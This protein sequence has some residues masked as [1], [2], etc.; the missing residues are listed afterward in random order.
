MKWFSFPGRDASPESGFRAALSFILIFILLAAGIITISYIFFQSYQRSFRVEAERQ[1]EAVAELKINELLRWRIEREGD[2]N[3]FYNNSAFVG[4]VRRLYDQPEDVETQAQLQNWM[5]KIS[6]YGQYDRAWLMDTQSVTRLSVPGGQQPSAAPTMRMVS[7]VLQS[8]RP[9]FQDFYRNEKDQRVYLAVMVPIFDESNASRPLGVLVLRIDPTAYLY[10]FIQRWPVPGAK[11][12]ETLLVRREENEVVY[13]NELRFQADTALNLRFPITRTNLPAVKVALGQEGVVEGTDYRGIP[14]LAA[15]KAVPDSPWFMVTRQDKAEVFSPIR[16]RLYQMV[17]AIGLMLFSAA[18]CVGLVWRQQRVGFY[19]EKILTMKALIKS[20]AVFRSYF[21]LPLH[22]LAV[23]SVEKGW[24]KV[25][26]HLCSILGYTREEIVRM[27]WAE[28]THPRDLDADVEQF[29]RLLAGQIEKYEM[30]KRFVR[31]DGAVV[32]TAIAAGCVREADG[33]ADHFICSIDDITA[34]K[35][36]EEKLA[37]TIAELRASNRDLEQFAYIASHD[38][39]EPLRMVA[40][41][42]QLLERRYKDKL[43]QDANDFIGFAVDGALRMRQ[44]IDSLLEYSQV[45]T[46]QRSFEPV[47]LDQVLPGVLRDLEGSVLE[48]SAQ[49]TADPLPHVYGDALQLGLVLQNLISNALKFHGE[50]SPEVHIAAEELSK[51]WKITVRDNGIGIEPQYQERIFKIFQRLHSHA[52]YPG[53]GIGLT[54]CKRIV[55]RHGGETGVES[56]YGKGSSF[57]FTLPK[58]G[59]K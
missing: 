24:L 40:G 55:E 50:K 26:D 22:G 53:T 23:T 21:E 35:A 59:E 29:N 19:R 34:R 58:K 20:D 52:E 1:L 3:V 18:A 16:Q 45:Q 27:T 56:E 49:I 41:Y 42:V 57:W 37:E 33:A 51:Y 9:V 44:L 8:G 4:L 28:M 54:V 38:M 48:T 43:D 15:I 5:S 13:L 10:P 2:G 32:L 31:K 14:V 7:E 25:N 36:G 17:A 11:T 6:R 30:E 46:R 47:D 12:A 39:Q